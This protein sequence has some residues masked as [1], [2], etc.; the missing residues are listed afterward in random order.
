LVVPAQGQGDLNRVIAKTH[1]LVLAAQN[2]RA[3]S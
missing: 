3:L 2:A 1:L